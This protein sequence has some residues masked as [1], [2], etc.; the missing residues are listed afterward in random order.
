MVEL[1]LGV[2]GISFVTAI[3][4]PWI[5]VQLGFPSAMAMSL[6][7][8]LSPL[9]CSYSDVV[10]CGAVRCGVVFPACR[11]LTYGTGRSALVLSEKGGRSAM[12][13]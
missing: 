1:L 7:W 3:A 9:R 5:A 8:W 6:W 10:G 12:R 2:V 11:K 4:A 13:S